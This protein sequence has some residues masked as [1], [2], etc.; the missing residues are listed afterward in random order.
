MTVA[1]IPASHSVTRNGARVITPAL[2]VCVYF[3]ELTDPVR[4]GLRD[5]WQRVRTLFERKLAWYV[6]E[7]MPEKQPVDEEALGM[8][9]FWFRPGATVRDRYV[10]YSYAGESENDVGPCGVEL[11]VLNP[12]PI[13]EQYRALYSALAKTSVDDAGKQAN[14]L[15]LSFAP[16]ADE[17]SVAQFA[18][19][20]RFIFTRIPFLSGYAGYALLFDEDSAAFTGEAWE[21][22]LRIAMRHPGYDVFQYDA[23][24][25]FLYFHAKGAN[26]ITALGEPFLERFDQLERAAYLRDR[27]IDITRTD[28][29][30]VIQAGA[31]PQ[32]GDL[33]R[34]DD[35]P[36]YRQVAKAIEPLTCGAHWAF[37]REFNEEKTMRWIKRFDLA[38]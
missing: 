24:S 7:S 37:S 1:E 13:P 21:A 34:G 35:L 6:T 4:Q 27:R 18:D 2:S 8:L 31:S 36:L 28:T 25:P 29:M 5:V 9:D 20:C 30:L 14:C 22:I 32:I 19:L 16:P 26:W 38:G 15:R 3:G 17:A 11:W 12:A 33:N 10:F 23:G